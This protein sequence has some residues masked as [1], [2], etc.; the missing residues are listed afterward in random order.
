MGV[1][2]SEV[3]FH[4][5]GGLPEGIALKA[6][7]PSGASSGFLPASMVDV[8][9]DFKS[10]AQVGSML[11]SGAILVVA[12]GTC[13]VDLA[14]NVAKFFRNE[15]CGKCVPCR[16]GSQKIVDI[17][18][19]V[20]CGKG[21]SQ[22]LDLIEGLEETLLLTSICGLGQVVPNPI[23]SVVTYFKD[24]VDD[25]VERKHCASGVCFS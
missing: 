17:L 25:H 22:D 19:D 20:T 14:L 2:A 7:A 24:E 10:L 8:P 21:S 16:I 13:M 4:L 6:F 15:S 23:K 12:Q 11:G 9:L 1:S 5:A 18:T 3:I